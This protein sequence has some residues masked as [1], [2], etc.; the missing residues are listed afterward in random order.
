MPAKVETSGI[1]PLFAA[2]REYKSNA[3]AIMGMSGNDEPRAMPAGED[4]RIGHMLNIENLAVVGWGRR[5]GAHGA[6]AVAT[7]EPSFVSIPLPK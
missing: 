2:S 4:P 3:G 5:S 7:I 1:E 6:P